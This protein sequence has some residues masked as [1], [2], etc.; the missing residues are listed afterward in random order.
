M[1]ENYINEGHWDF[2]G[3]VNQS[4]SRLLMADNELEIVQNGELE[5][6]GSISKV[7]GYTQ[8]GSDVNTGYD[9]LGAVY[10]Y[11]PSDGTQKQIVIADGAANSDAYTYNP[12]TGAWTIH[13]L[14]L[15]T[16]AKAEFEYFLDGFFMVNFEDATRW[17]DLTQ[18]Y[19]TTNVTNAAKAKYIKLYKSRIYL[20]YVVSG[21][22][23]YPS[24]IT[25]SD[26]PS[27]GTIAWDDSVNYFDVEEEDG[28]VIRGLEVNADRLLIF[29]E[30]SLHRYDT[31]TRYKVP[32][33][34]GTVSQRSV[35]NIQG[36]TLYLHHTGLWGYD[37]S[38]STLLSRRIKDIIDGVSTKNLV[39]ACAYVKGDHYYLYLGDIINSAKGL[40]IDKCLLD[41]DIA[42]N[43]F[44]WRSLEKTPT[45][46][47]KYPDDRTNVTYDLATVSYN[48]SDVA[49]GGLISSEERMYFGAT[50]G[51]VYQVDTGRDYDGTD[52]PF[53]VETK[54]Y[55]LGQPSFYKMLQKVQIYVNSG[56]G[57]QVQYKLDDKD[58]RTLG[59][60][61][62]T[63]SELIFKAAS[64]CKRV[65][66]RFSEASSGG[67]FSIEGLDIFFTPE[68]LIA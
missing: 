35:K 28:D 36:W 41:Y 37:G 57:I 7:R 25:Y 32:G 27:S 66:F 11:K 63:Q 16:G 38:S 33:C 19:T 54:N 1:A 4:V 6:V 5:K 30:N 24:K 31:N 15:T 18:W 2:S 46:F 14:S 45:V 44:T 68:T 12:I 49:Y 56:K 17:N 22:S 60:V 40:E 65:K 59:R 55:Y 29:K 64:R 21:G 20:A 8:R 62:D 3:G 13:N 10:G 23:T 61:G 53:F 58:W 50:D 52:I 47:E 39:N 34:P 9:I 42:K 51:A 26:L 67:R 48:D 43:A